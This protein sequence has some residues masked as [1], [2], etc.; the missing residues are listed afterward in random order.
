MQSA[1]LKTFFSLT[2]LF[3]RIANYL[4]LLSTLAILVYSS[5][6]IDDTTPFGGLAALFL[7]CALPYAANGLILYL[8]RRHGLASA[9]AGT[10]SFLS[11]LIGA[12]VYTDSLILKKS[13]LNFFVLLANPGFQFGIAAVTGLIVWIT[14]FTP[15][16]RTDGTP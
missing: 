7:F 9:V 11:A 15:G 3:G 8:A 4:G 13:L 14:H 2:A 10:G 1:S 12:V 16:G 5:F 6:P